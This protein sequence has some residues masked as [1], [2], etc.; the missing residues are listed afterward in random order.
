LRTASINLGL[1]L[2]RA[3]KRRWTKPLCGGGERPIA[4]SSF[5]CFGQPIQ[6]PSLKVPSTPRAESRSAHA[7]LKICLRA[8]APTDRHR[9]HSMRSMQKG[10]S[11]LCCRPAN[12][13]LGFFVMIDQRTKDRAAAPLSARAHASVRPVLLLHVLL[14]DCLLRLNHPVA[15]NRCVN[16]GPV[17]S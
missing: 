8:D 11:G 3:L 17:F 6:K 14:A 2:L 4:Y 12:R 15:T 7:P 10:N 9:Y 13:C 16:H 1:F 5:R